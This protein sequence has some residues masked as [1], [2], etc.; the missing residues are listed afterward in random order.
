VARLI[1][2]S[3]GERRE[4]K[5]TGPISIG[6]DAKATVQVDDKT[7]SREHTQVFLQGG[8]LYVRDLESKNGTFLNGALIRQPELLKH[9][10]R[11]K[12]GPAVFTVALEAGDT[13]PAVTAAVAPAPRP[14][15]ARA[16]APAPAR[17]SRADQI[18]EEAAESDFMVLVFRAL[19]VGVVILGA[20]FTKPIFAAILDH[21]PK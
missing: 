5:V 16:P 15:A 18:R 6:R 21:I 10:D 14:A 2:E 20:Y 12:V 13:M 4:I 9:G 3:G 19:L 1:L 17:T 8:R 11:I 7:L